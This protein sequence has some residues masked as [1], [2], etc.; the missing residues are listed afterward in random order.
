MAAMTDSLVCQNDERCLGAKISEL[1]MLILNLCN[2][3]IQFLERLWPIYCKDTDKTL[4]KKDAEKQV[5][6]AGVIRQ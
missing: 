3:L 6:I 5:W 4:Q 1:W 2:E